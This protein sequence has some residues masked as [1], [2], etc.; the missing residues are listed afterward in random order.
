MNITLPPEQREWLE[1]RVADGHFDSID[2]A[3]TV[4]VADLMAMHDDDLTW[5]K[6]YVDQARASLQRGDVLSGDEYLE[7]LDSKIQSL[8][9]R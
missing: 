3:L 4:A 6:P 9:R 5:A 8:R 7:R 2:E 1:A